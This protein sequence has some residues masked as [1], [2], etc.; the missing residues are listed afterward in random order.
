MRRVFLLAL[1]SLICPSLCVKST[2]LAAPDRTITL[3]KLS[4]HTVY[5]KIQINILKLPKEV[6]AISLT[7]NENRN[8]SEKQENG[9]MSSLFSNKVEREACK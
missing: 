8:K 3:V 5:L 1:P 7:Q 2:I 9:Y 6:G 4:P